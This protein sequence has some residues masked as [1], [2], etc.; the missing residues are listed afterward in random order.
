M[1]EQKSTV[2]SPNDLNFEVEHV[3]HDETVI[4]LLAEQTDVTRRKVVTGRVQVQTVTREASASVPGERRL[5]Q[6]AAPRHVVGAPSGDPEP[7]LVISRTERSP[8]K[9]K[10]SGPHRGSSRHRIVD[11]PD[12]RPSMRN[13]SASRTLIELTGT[14][15]D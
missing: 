3:E 7:L 9:E 12:T 8:S 15:R 2:E 10:K 14:M 6:M 1:A 5:C 11:R 4:A 13:G